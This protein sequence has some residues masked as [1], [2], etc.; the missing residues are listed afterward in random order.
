VVGT[1]TFLCARITSGFPAGNYW[2]QEIIFILLKNTHFLLILAHG[3]EQLCACRGLAGPDQLVYPILVSTHPGEAML[4]TRL[5]GIDFGTVRVGLA[6]SDPDRKIASPLATLTRRTPAQDETYLR[7]L[8]AR[9]L[10]GGLVVGL[11]VHLNGTEGAKAVQARA[12]AAWLT[13]ITGLS[14]VLFDERFTSV[15]AER[16]LLGAGL[17]NQR[18][19]ERRD[20]VAAQILLQSY[21]DAGCPPET[22]PTA[23]DA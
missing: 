12:Y 7:T 21:L 13:Q 23:L 17:T 8:C 22:P 3:F 10:V 18:R 11:P 4:A 5:L 1:P 20:R 6:I 19:K 2:F 14:A 16:A 15:E 9:E